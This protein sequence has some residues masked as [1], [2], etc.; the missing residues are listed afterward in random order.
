ALDEQTGREVVVKRI[1]PERLQ[2][3]TIA[4]RFEREIKALIET[5]EGDVLWRAFIMRVYDVAAMPDGGKALI[6][7]YIKDPDLFTQ[8]N[9]E[10][11]PSDRFSASVA[12]QVCLALE[13]AHERGVIHR[14]VKTENI[15]LHSGEHPERGDVRVRVG[16]F[17]VAQLETVD[18]SSKTPP[19]GTAREVARAGGRA[20]KRLTDFEYVIGTPYYLA[21]ES[22]AEQ[23]YDRRSDLY[24]LGVVM[25]R[26]IAGQFPFRSKDKRAILDMHL[27]ALPVP[28]HEVRADKKTSP[29]EPIVMKLLEKDPKKRYQTALEAAQAIKEAMVTADSS[30]HDEE[31]YC[32]VA[33]RKKTSR[34]AAETTER[35]AVA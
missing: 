18:A 26:M 15:F 22:I 35:R 28:P 34:Q 23:K 24:S 5:G 14:D 3:K 11:I 19:R 27:D 12:L 29:L 30:L 31:P 17:G 10:R 9:R 8:L 2:D 16:D 20:E 4:A 21:P 1:L 6:M 25:Y 13:A 7:E 33:D 32:W